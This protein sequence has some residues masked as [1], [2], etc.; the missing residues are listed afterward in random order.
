MHK[1]SFSQA[2]SIVWNSLRIVKQYKTHAK[3][4]PCARRVRINFFVPVNCCLYYQ[5]NLIKIEN[6]IE[7]VPNGINHAEKE[8]PSFHDFAHRND[9]TFSFIYY[10]VFLDVLLLISPHLEEQ[11][12]IKL[13]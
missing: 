7:I 11:N 10:L 1:V 4:T 5:I 8:C 6:E 13:R 12:L 9:D 3:T 2:F